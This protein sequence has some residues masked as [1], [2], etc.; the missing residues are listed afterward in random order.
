MSNLKN[1]KIVQIL[2]M[3][4]PRVINMCMYIE[5]LMLCHESWVMDMGHGSE[6]VIDYC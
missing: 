4:H 2:T 3:E 5:E 6:S 1:S